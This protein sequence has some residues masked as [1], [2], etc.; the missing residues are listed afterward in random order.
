MLVMHLSQLVQN[1]NHHRLLSV[2]RAI[3][4]SVGGR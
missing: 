3:A 1:N 4:H 2:H